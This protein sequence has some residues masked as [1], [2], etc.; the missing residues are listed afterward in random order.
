MEHQQLEETVAALALGA[1]DDADPATERALLEHLAGCDSC[2]ALFNDL[3]EVG[4][5]LALAAAPRSVPQ[6]VEERIFEAIRERRPRSERV[7]PPRRSIAARLGAAAAA[8]AIVALF[9]WNL[10][11]TS[12]VNTTRTRSEQVARALSLVGAPDAHSATLAGESGSLV[13]V[14]RAGEAMLV[15]HDVG[16]PPS[17]RVLQLWLLRAG[18]ATSVGVFSPSDGLVVVPVSI[19]PM[20]FD[21]VA[22]TVERGPRGARSPTGSPVYSGSLASA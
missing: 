4:A 18:V 6:A 8:A 15:G 7:A 20:G 11:L 10:Q 3:R 5:D 21:R 17:G 2:R 14:Y 19:D 12:R 22:V 16:S 1:L 13:F 9:A